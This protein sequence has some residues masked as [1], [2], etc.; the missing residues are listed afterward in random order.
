MIELYSNVI[1]EYPLRSTLTEVKIIYVIN[2][3][4]EDL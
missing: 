2:K 1:R 4:V 3:T